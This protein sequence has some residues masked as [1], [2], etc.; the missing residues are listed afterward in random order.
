MRRC[1]TLDVSADGYVRGEACLATL[2]Q[3]FRAS[4]VQCGGATP[5]PL[6]CGTATNQ[7]GRSGALTAPSGPAQQAVI[8][9]AL[10]AADLK[11][12]TLSGAI[13]DPSGQIIPSDL[14]MWYDPQNAASCAKTADLLQGSICELHPSRGGVTE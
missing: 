2:L 8:K 11:P 5:L 9:A 6:L 13:A 3:P 10:A 1:K 14:Q 12:E 7:D 4:A